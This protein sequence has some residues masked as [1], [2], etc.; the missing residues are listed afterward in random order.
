[1]RPQDST[2]SKTPFSSAVALSW[3]LLAGVMI[4]IAVA[5]WPPRAQADVAYDASI[6]TRDTA[7]ISK[8]KAMT[9]GTAYAPG[10]KIGILA[11]VA[12]NV[13]LDLADGVS[14]VTVAVPVGYTQ[15]DYAVTKVETGGTATATYY[16]LN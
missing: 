4:G 11:T 14:S 5:P 15:F 10:R 13:T 12:G 2:P 1:M 6:Q 16:D 8:A 3:A 7:P 9:V